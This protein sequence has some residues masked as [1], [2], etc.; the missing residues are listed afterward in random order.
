M[1]VSASRRTDIPAFYTEWLMN[2][3]EAG[4]VMVRNPRRPRR[5]S[6]LSLTP[7]AAE[8]FVFWTKNPAPLLDR[9]PDLDDRGYAYYFQF[10]LTPYGQEWEK[11]LPPKRELLETFQKLAITAGPRGIV[12]RYDPVI[13]TKETSVAYH[14][15]A[16]E[17]LAARLEGM[18]DECVFSFVDAYAAFTRRLGVP[19][20]AVG[21]E[22]AVRLAE[23]F[24]ASALRH[25][26]RLS[27]CCEGNDLFGH[28]VLPA[29]CIDPK[30]VSDRM[31]SSVQVSRDGN[32]RT[33]CGCAQSV[34][35]GAYDSCDHGCV[36]CYAT[37]SGR[38]TADNRTRHDPR[39]PLLIGWPEE[40]DEIVEYCRPSIR[41]AQTS[42]FDNVL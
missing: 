17:S 18:T 13:L 26:M 21:H 5:V 42:L 1:I 41:A 40:G 6:R 30:R 10:T 38:L 7:E 29:A 24:A 35:I 2:R 34:D 39:S 15:N 20:D 28:G 19:P 33:G 25:G 36:Y 8:C 27:S 22:D 9:L 11:N 3:L 32:Q 16:F 31:G 4:S 14:L 23:G 37:H 12:W